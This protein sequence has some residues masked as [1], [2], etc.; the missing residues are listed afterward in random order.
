[1]RIVCISDTHGIHDRM[2]HQ[3]PEG[4]ILL[5]AGDLTL[6][7]NLEDLASVNDFFESLPHPH[8]IFI[9]GNHDW[10]FEREEKE[11]RNLMTSATCLIDEGIEIDGVKIWGS[12]WQPEFHAWA[13]NLPRGRKLK[14]AWDKIPDDSDIV[15]T[16]GPPRGILD[17]CSDGAREGCDDL[18]DRIAQIQPKLH[19][20]GHIHEGY[21]LEIHDETTHI[22]ASICDLGYRPI[23][24]PVV[25]EINLE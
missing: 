14:E 8:K 19:L 1:M 11:A 4:D 22:N 17:L 9:P 18:R 16:H 3:I 5:H 23:N 24:A 12:P 13:F 7:G 15:I 25:F 21:G 2:E 20:F 6:R 10:C